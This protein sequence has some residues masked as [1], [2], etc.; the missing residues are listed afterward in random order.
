MDAQDNK[1]LCQGMYQ[2]Q[3]R[4][5]FAGFMAAAAD[6]IEITVPGHNALLPWS[7]N[8]KGKNSIGPWLQN[9]GKHIKIDKVELKEFVADG[10]K[11]V[12]FL[13]EWLTVVD[14][15]FS[16][17]LDEIHVHTVKDGLVAD[18]TMYEDTAKVVAALRGKEVTD[19]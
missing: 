6:D 3:A 12:I 1:A 4:G 7:V 5:D 10:D 14:N 13:R 2:A 17:E 8:V 16:F 18:I 9:M 11:V 15:G 19:L